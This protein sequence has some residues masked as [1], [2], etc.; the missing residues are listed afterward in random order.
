MFAQIF[1]GCKCG[2]TWR[3]ENVEDIDTE[4]DEVYIIPVCKICNQ[5]VYEKIVNGNPCFHALTDEEM[6]WETYNP[7]AEDD[8]WEED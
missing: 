7:D 5:P 1:T 6:F 4:N 2:D 8:D 3:V